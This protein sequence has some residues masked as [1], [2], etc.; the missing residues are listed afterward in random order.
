MNHAAPRSVTL[1]VLAHRWLLRLYPRA[2]QRRFADEMIQVFRATCQE[3]WRHGG[4]WELLALT[5]ATAFDVAV[6]AAREHVTRGRREWGELMAPGA[7]DRSGGFTA[8]GAIILAALVTTFGPLRAQSGQLVSLSADDVV[9]GVRLLSVVIALIVIGAMA[10]AQ[11]T[12][13][14]R[15]SGCVAL[16]GVGLHFFFVDLWL[17]TPLLHAH[18]HVQSWLAAWGGSLVALSLLGGIGLVFATVRYRELEGWRGGALRWRRWALVGS[19]VGLLMAL[20]LQSRMTLAT[21]LLVVGAFSA[22]AVWA[23]LAGT[24]L[25]LVRSSWRAHALRQATS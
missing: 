15:C 3:S 1:A 17:V 25:G 21:F 22:L 7:W 23:Y 6:T 13:I 5:L 18:P 12:W 16:I 19:G 9:D 4:G 11:R 14:G 2:F 8:A 24:A 10:P 20:F